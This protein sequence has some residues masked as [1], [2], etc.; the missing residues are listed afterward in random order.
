MAVPSSGSI[1]LAGLA[2]EKDKDDY[3][4]VDYDDT[5]SLKDVTLG[6]DAN[7]SHISFDVTNGFSAQHPNSQAS[8]G[9]SEFYGYDHD[10]AA[11][12]C[13]MAY[14]S[15]NQG[16]FDYPITLWSD[17]GTVTIEYQAYSIPD[18]FVFTWN[19]NTYTSG[20]GNGT[21]A[22]FVGAANQLSA[23]QATTGNGSATIT[24]LT[25][26]YGSGSQNTQS[27]GRGT[28]TFNKNSS[29]SSANMRV[30]AP[31]GGTA[32]WFSVS[33]PGSQVIGGGTG[34]APTVVTNTESNVGENGFTMNGT[35]NNKGLASDFSTT[36]TITHRGFVTKTGSITDDFIAGE[37][38]VGI[39]VADNTNSTGAFS[40]AI[41]S[42]SAATTYTYRAYAT[43]AAGTTYG[44]NEQVTTLASATAP[45]IVSN[46]ASSVSSNGMTMNGNMTSTGNATI[47]DKGFVYSSSDSTPTIGEFGVTKLSQHPGT[48][49]TTGSYSRAVTGLSSA[50]TY[51]YRA[52]ATNS[53]GTSD[54]SVISQ[55]TSTSYVTRYVAGPYQ[56]SF[57]ACYQTM[58]TIIRFTGTFGNG[59]RIY[60]NNLN[61]ITNDGWY[62]GPPASTSGATSAG[63]FYVNSSGYVSSF[64]ALGC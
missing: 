9:M 47:T 27:G 24:T 7:G 57:F 23:L 51:Y 43:N 17:T 52:F 1:S 25:T 38:G 22:G 64:S 44:A 39:Q 40:K 30:F 56:K 62:A 28:I 16:T 4:D 50:T 46:L 49:N 18:K 31:L 19:G 11:P 42:L 32:W 61:V 2:A 5:I 37:S 15:G 48:F 3:T 8:Y 10:A 14:Q 26:S 54:G 12:A 35:V 53:V 36:A 34:V 41:S 29:T 63:Y 55:P 21:G 60:D 13:N 45:G 59:T 33:C 20:S 58:S 6:G